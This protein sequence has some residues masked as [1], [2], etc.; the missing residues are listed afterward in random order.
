MLFTS[1]AGVGLTLVASGV[2]QS[3]LV[4]KGK[5]ELADTL[6]L[7]TKGSVLMYAVYYV[8]QLA[9]VMTSVFL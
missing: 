4:K 1:V 3:Q 2:A 6:D 5:Q 7:V 8:W 9:S